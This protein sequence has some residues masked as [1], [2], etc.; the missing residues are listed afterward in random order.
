MKV[1]EESDSI[2]RHERELHANREFFESKPLL[3]EIYGDF[4]QRIGSWL[5]GETGDRTIVELGSGMGQA[6]QFLPDCITT[7]LFDNDYVDRVESVYDLQFD[8]G[9]VDGFFMVDVFHHLRFPSIAFDQMRRCLRP[10]GRIVLLEPDVS[11]VGRVVFGML[12]PEPLGLGEKIDW[13]K[14]FHSDTNDVES[15]YA[16]QGNGHRTF[17]RKENIEKV[18]PLTAIHVERITSLSYVGSGGFSGPQLYPQALLPLMRGIDRMLSPF[19]GLFSTRLFV[20]LEA[21]IE[22]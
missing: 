14:E 3:K 12:H 4:Y 17:V 1:S 11:L 2:I 18:D 20:V 21:P 7:D 9:S 19:P 8:D 15:Y 5:P 13:R 22:E 6:K 16:A 10:G